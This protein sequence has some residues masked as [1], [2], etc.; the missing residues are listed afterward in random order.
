MTLFFL[1][2]ISVPI[3]DYFSS[4]NISGFMHVRFDDSYYEYCYKTDRVLTFN[5]VHN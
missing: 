3:D 4:S 2:D 5:S 1:V